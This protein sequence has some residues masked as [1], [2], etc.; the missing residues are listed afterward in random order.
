LDKIPKDT[1]LEEIR[2]SGGYRP[3]SAPRLRQ[4]F[5]WR[6]EATPREA[7]HPALSAPLLTSGRLIGL[8]NIYSQEE[9][10]EF[11]ADE[12]DLT[13]IYANQVAVA[14]RNASLIDELQDKIIQ[15]EAAQ[16]ELVKKERMEQELALARQVQQSVL[17]RTF[18]QIHGYR[19]AARNLPAR[20]V[21]G[22]FY[23]VIPLG[24]S[25][26]GV[27]IA[28]VSDKGMPAAL[29]MAL[30]RSL[31]LA[32]ARRECSPRAVLANVNQILLELGGANMSE[33]GEPSMFVTV[34]YGVIDGAARQI[35]YARAGHDHPF[36]VR[37]RDVQQLGGQ[38]AILGLFEEEFLAM[39]E[40]R[41][42]LAPGDRL[43]LYTDGVT[44]VLSPEDEP[45]GEERLKAFLKIHGDLSPRELC[46][47]TFAELAAY[48][49]GA[50]QF[51]DM[52]LLVAEVE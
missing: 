5:S 46:D 47:A 10:R 49:A 11:T 17:P 52:A 50:D 24:G 30:T 43:V 31:I 38:G 8:L 39:S 44:D 14:V 45:F 35:T 40:E 15:L 27:V 28:D 26:F 37:G 23:D 32:E 9:R 25:R 29:Y 1:V 7:L 21:G 18:P 13:M 34:F 3:M 12:A 16:V 51:D 36:L 41:I 6:P 48:Q 22:D 2:R 33:L 19:F 4:G 42:D 20:Q